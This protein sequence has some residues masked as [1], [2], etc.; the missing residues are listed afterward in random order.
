MLCNMRSEET[1]IACD[2]RCTCKQTPVQHTRS[3]QAAFR[4]TNSVTN[5]ASAT[6]CAVLLRFRNSAF[7]QTPRSTN[8][9]SQLRF[10]LF[11][12][13]LILRVW[14]SRQ[15]ACR[16]DVH[17]DTCQ[18]V[19]DDIVNSNLKATAHQF[20][21]TDCMQVC[22]RDR[23]SSAVSMRQ[24]HR[25][26]KLGRRLMPV[27][28][29]VEAVLVGMLLVLLC[30]ARPTEAATLQAAEAEARKVLSELNAEV[31]FPWPNLV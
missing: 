23:G 1:I 10:L 22:V 24:L 29:A 7:S 31:P 2:K 3:A 18:L 4:R 30:L 6:N 5:Q 19:V 13:Q 17:R 15:H 12:H 8:H 9:R 25:I 21:V 11:S 26:K 16:R 28:P 27:T 20:P 14:L